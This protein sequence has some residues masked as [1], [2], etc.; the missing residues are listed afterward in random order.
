MSP[1][2][3]EKQADDILRQ[4]ARDR[5]FIKGKSLRGYGEYARKHGIMTSKQKSVVEKTEKT[6]FDEN[7]LESIIHDG[8]DAATRRKYAAEDS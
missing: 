3:L 6:G 2:D 7:Q 8:V 1:K 4:D 5:G